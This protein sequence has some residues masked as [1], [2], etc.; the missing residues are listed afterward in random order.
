[1]IYINCV[2]KLFILCRIGYVVIS[3]LQ[4]IERIV[5]IKKGLKNFE[6]SEQTLIKYI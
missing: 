2:S 1:M 4:F 5:T 6:S 3:L